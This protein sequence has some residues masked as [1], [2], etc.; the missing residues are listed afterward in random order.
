MESIDLKNIAFLTQMIKIML[1]N[2]NIK[3]QIKN[4]FYKL[5]N[6]YKNQF[7]LKLKKL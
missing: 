6:F 5:N 3:N 7:N 1:K 2:F 4:R